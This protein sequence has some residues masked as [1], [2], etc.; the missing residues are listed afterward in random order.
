MPLRWL[1]R[2]R[3]GRAQGDREGKVRRELPRASRGRDVRRTSPDLKPRE[4]ARAQGRAGRTFDDERASPSRVGV[5]QTALDAAARGH[6]LADVVLADETRLRILKDATGKPLRR[7]HTKRF[8]RQKVLHRAGARHRRAGA[9]ERPLH[10]RTARCSAR[11]LDKLEDQQSR[12]SPESPLGAAIDTRSCVRR[13]RRSDPSSSEAASTGRGGRGMP[14][15]AAE[16]T[17]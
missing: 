5:A 15:A 13:M 17:R 1:H 14:P 11:P 4:G 3:A 8:S 6:L 2:D 10:T 16:A 12:Q 7:S 9:S